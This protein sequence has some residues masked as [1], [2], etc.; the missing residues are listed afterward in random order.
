MNDSLLELIVLC[1][2][3]VFIIFIICNIQTK[4]HKEYFETSKCLMTQ[5]EYNSLSNSWETSKTSDNVD[6]IP[7]TYIP[8]LERLSNKIGNKIEN[9][10]DNNNAVDKDSSGD[11]P[12]C[13]YAKNLFKHMKFSPEHNLG[14]GSLSTYCPNSLNAP[15]AQL[16]LR[17]LHSSVTDVK[18]LSTIQLQSQLNN[19]A[20]ENNKATEH[21][22]LLTKNIDSKLKKQYVDYYL[23]YH[24]PYEDA[25]HKFR[26]G[27]GTIDELAS[28][29]HPPM[30]DIEQHDMSNITG[31]DAT[32]NDIKHLHGHYNFDFIHLQTVMKANTQIQINDDDINKLAQSNIVLEDTGLYIQYADGTEQNGLAFTSVKNIPNIKTSQE[33]AYRLTGQNGTYDLH[34]I[35]DNILYLKITMTANVLPSQFMYG[36]TYLL[37]K[38]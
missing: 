9:C 27:I 16:C 2:G 28:T 26:K 8:K 20:K 29:M 14:F 13:R 30:I 21:S 15:G 24:K 33:L 38:Q 37:N 19:I 11:C 23:T 5:P 4:R 17:K 25:S 3:F 1:I 22:E 12:D 31:V 35:S 10:Y 7:K 6:Y 36:V 34:P 18:N 32:K